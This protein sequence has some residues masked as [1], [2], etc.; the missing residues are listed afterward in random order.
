MADQKITDLNALTAVAETDVLVAVDVSATETKKA[1]KAVLL[2]PI[3][4]NG[5]NV[6]I[7]TSSPTAKLTVSAGSG[8][9]IFVQDSVPSGSGPFVKVQGKRSDGNQSQ[10]FS[11][12]LLLEGHR[13]DAAVASGKHLGSVAFGGNHTD[14]DA[15][16]ILY[17]ASIS[18]VAEGAFSDA[19]TMPTALAF[20]AGS[21]GRSD[22]TANVTFGDEHM[23]ITS[24]GNVGIGLANPAVPLHV[25]SNTPS[26][27]FT[28]TDDNTDT[29][30]AGGAGGVLVLDADINNEAAGSAILFRVDG[31]SEKMRIT[32]AGLLGIGISN[33]AAQL[34]VNG[35]ITTRAA[36]TEGGQVNF[37]NPDN[38]STGLTV[39]VSAADR[40]RIWQAR[41]NSL[42][43]IG[44]I[45]STGGTVALYTAAA[46]RLTINPVGS[47][48]INQASPT[49]KLDVNGTFK[50]NAGNHPTG[51][52]NIALGDLA[53]NDYT[54]TTAN[55]VAISHQAARYN[56]ASHNVAIGSSA[57]K[58]A[59]GASSGGSNIA[60]GT[61]AGVAVTTA[62][63]SVL[64]GHAAAQAITTGAGNVILGASSAAALV[65]GSN[66]TCIGNSVATLLSSGSANVILGVNAGD[67]TTTGGN[68][69]I[70][71][72]GAAAS[73][74]TVSNEITLGNAS[75]DALRIPGVGF[76]IDS[77]DVGINTISPS[78]RLDV[79]G[80]TVFST[81][82]HTSNLF[83]TYH[84][85]GNTS[86]LSIKGVRISSG[87]SWL[88]AATRI[89][90]KTDST[91]QGY[92]QFNGDNDSATTFGYNNVEKMRM[93]SGGN[94]GIGTA[95]PTA[96]LD[97]NG[98][99]K[100]N[101]GNHPVG[102]NNIA[103]GGNAGANWIGTTF[104][105]ASI[106]VKAS[107][108]N[109]GVYNI[110]M[111][112]FALRGASGTSTGSSN[113]AIG[114]NAGMAVT[115]AN[116]SV[117]IGHNAGDSITEGGGNVIL[118]ANSAVAL[119]DG[120]N[121]VCIGNSVAGLLS[122]GINN[123]VIG[124]NAGDTTTT[125][126]N[127][128]ILGYGAA[129]S[130]A[131]VN[132]EITLGNS[133][134]AA[135]RC[136]VTSI[137]ALSD[138]RDKTDITDLDLGL[139]YINAL[140]PVEFVWA[141]R[142][143]DADN[144]RQG[145]KEAGFIAQELRSAED[146]FDASWLGTVLDTNPDRLEASPGKLLPIVIKALQE[147]SSKITE[148]TARINTLEGN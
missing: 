84:S 102:T 98:S 101:A 3:T 45:A 13:T 104:G 57:L 119:V 37:Y 125:G 39:D 18:G 113:V 132:N 32:S 25:S 33:P 99:F 65:D 144:P 44:Q 105:S 35:S 76:Y 48:G 56:T 128:I 109:T 31:S 17:P 145:T 147:A 4:A 72:Y 139:D 143:A 126:D 122:S 59:S 97:V 133:S 146:Q 51:T 8:D 95:S 40:G 103:L 114:S 53:G 90:Q 34:D 66:N 38:L 140:R 115:T 134:I 47:I 148:L 120:T 46:Q 142:N 85:N 82:G 107:E 73:S 79:H 61:H 67:T 121:N 71:G 29:Q 55:T 36:G 49:A 27:R 15:A 28:D 130:S 11:G 91:A 54:G 6:G 60:I 93:K 10:S 123:V 21:T 86:Y 58:G 12:K 63:T 26:I 118:G 94:F 111:G 70:L 78:A 1:T 141:M 7:N 52:A 23:R 138:M 5:T 64:I 124:V 135:L 117:L 129:S 43:Q 88:T 75:I 81:A 80:D 137:T 83:E 22:N 100:L 127:N 136:Q 42:M 89:E 2:A 110:A 116:T 16:N 92:I 9:G 69:T 112:L 106:G 96:K 14:G 30:I 62:G 19:A 20:S 68:N 41:P 87:T 74:A 24:A 108:F 77:G 131:T 50:L